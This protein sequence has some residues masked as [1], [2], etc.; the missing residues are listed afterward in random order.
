LKNSKFEARNPKQYQMTKI[1]NS[2]LFKTF[3]VLNLEVVSS[4]DIRVSDLTERS[5]R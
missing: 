2:K 1:R 3:E 4:F 5:E